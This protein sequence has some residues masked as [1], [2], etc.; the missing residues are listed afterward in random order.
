MNYLSNL[1]N[2]QL[3]PLVVNLSSE[4]GLEK[5]RKKVI[6]AHNANQK[7]NDFVNAVQKYGTNT[8]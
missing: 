5:L 7:Y 2:K 4:S 6:A 8:K 3:V 1:K